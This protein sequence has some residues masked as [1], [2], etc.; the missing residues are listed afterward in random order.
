MSEVVVAITTVDNPFDP[1]DDNENWYMY[2]IS[3]ENNTCA[4]LARVAKVSNQMSDAEYT[5]EVE[6]AIDS[7]IKNVDYSNKYRKIKR[8]V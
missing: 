6:R 4:L 7:I 1:I 3:H 5:A 8:V 2:D